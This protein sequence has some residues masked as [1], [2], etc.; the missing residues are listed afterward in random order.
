MA[1]LGLVGALGRHAAVDSGVAAV[2]GLALE[3][4]WAQRRMAGLAK[5]HEPV[6]ATSLGARLCAIIRVRTDV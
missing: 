5:P 1:A 3:T 4:Y 6:Q 2:A